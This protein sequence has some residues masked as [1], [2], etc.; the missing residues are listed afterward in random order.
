MPMPIMS[1]SMSMSI[2]VVH[3]DVKVLLLRCGSTSMMLDGDVVVSTISEF[4][5]KKLLL[6]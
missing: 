1:M 2:E 3:Y 6:N 4:K 5:F